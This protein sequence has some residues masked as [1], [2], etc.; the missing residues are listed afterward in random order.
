MDHHCPWLNQCVSHFTFPHFIRFLFYAV[1]S[2]GYLEY[3]LYVRASVVWKS[4]HMPSYLGPTA[5]QLAHLFVLL[6]ANS[7]T[8]F[9]LII[10]LI[11]SLWALGGNVTAI[12]SWEIERHKTLLRRARYFGGYLDGPDGIKVRIQKQEF[13]YDIGIWNNVK[14]GMGGS[15]NVFGWFWPFSATPDR[16]TGL[17]FEVNE[18]EDPELSWPPPD[19]DRIPRISRPMNADSAFPVEHFNDAQ[20]EIEAFRRR[21]SEDMQR[22]NFNSPFQ[23]R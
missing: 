23:R 2:M 6:M 11:R 19:P 13:P 5:F 15:V 3:F 8:L 17:K 4:R 7:V 18:F 9:A 12:E 16:S 21:Q 14:A 20:K 1:F 10:L 22:R